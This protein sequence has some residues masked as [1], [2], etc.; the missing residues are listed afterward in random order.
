GAAQCSGTPIEV[1]D[2]RC[3]LSATEAARAIEVFE[4]VEAESVREG[5]RP[6]PGMPE[7]VAALG[8]W[9]LAAVTNKRRD[10]TVE[11]LKVTGL[12]PAFAVVLG[13]DSVP[14]KKPRSEEHTSEL[15]SRGHVVCRLLLGTKKPRRSPG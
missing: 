7:A 4:K 5:M 9:K 14:R 8:G 2:E 10:T 6:Y 1:I 12:L 11:A 15:Q 3:G 13:G